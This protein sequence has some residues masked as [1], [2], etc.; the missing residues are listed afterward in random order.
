LQPGV[1][2]ILQPGQELRL[3]LAF[4]GRLMRFYA[5]LVVL[6]V[7]PFRLI[8][9]Q[10]PAQV[11]VRVGPQF[12]VV[13]TGL[14]TDIQPET[15]YRLDR[16]LEQRVIAHSADQFAHLRDQCPVVVR[17]APTMSN[18]VFPQGTDGFAALVGVAWRQCVPITD[19]AYQLCT[20]VSDA[21]P[22]PAE[23]IILIVVTDTGSRAENWGLLAHEIT[24]V[25]GTVDGPLCPGHDD[26]LIESA[27]ESELS[28]AYWWY[29][30][31][32]MFTL[33]PHGLVWDALN[34]SCATSAAPDLCVEL[35]NILAD[36]QSA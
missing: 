34:S 36:D 4:G 29:G 7:I 30:V 35:A 17:F 12:H 15:I 24:H 26:Y 6:V 31:S 25:L 1:V 33:T 5:W 20:F 11:T 9:L 10:I 32:G 3:N 16:W 18:A 23:R 19:S 21:P 13:L 2:D 27:E 28:D 14:P 8:C 22:T